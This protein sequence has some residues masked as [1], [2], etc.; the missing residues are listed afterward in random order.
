MKSGRNF[1]RGGPFYLNKKI[2]KLGLGLVL[3]ACGCSKQ[4]SVSDLG[5]I[6]LVPDVPK[7]VK[8]GDADVT[9][10]EKRF[11]S[12]KLTVTAESG[13]TVTGKDIADGT[14]PP[15]LKAGATLMESVDLTTLPLNAEILQNFAGRPVRYSLR[16]DA[17]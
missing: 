8:A 12:G 7:H 3:F 13:R 1:P 2:S 15:R 9:F 16:Y 11:A 17:R 10:T 4:P 5:V 6:E 14:A